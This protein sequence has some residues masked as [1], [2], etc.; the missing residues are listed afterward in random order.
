MV[1][2]IDEFQS[3]NYQDLQSQYQSLKLSQFSP[4]YGTDLSRTLHVTVDRKITIFPTFSINLF[5]I[6]MFLLQIFKK[7]QETVGFQKF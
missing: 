4:F 5:M 1:Q 6:L 2:K 7:L 3:K